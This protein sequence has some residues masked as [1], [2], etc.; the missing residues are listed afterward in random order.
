MNRNKEELEVLFAKFDRDVMVYPRWYRL[1][2]ATDQWFGVLLW[3]TSM[4]ETISS[5][6]HRKKIK[7][8]DNWFDNLACWFLRKIESKHCLKSL[9]E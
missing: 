5:H 6:I 4:D 3:N 9:G 8:T 7:G 2:I 1:L